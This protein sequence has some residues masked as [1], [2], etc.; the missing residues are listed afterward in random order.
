MGPFNGLV[1]TS[2]LAF[3][4]VFWVFL[5]ILRS[6]I[7]FAMVFLPCFSLGA[8]ITLGAGAIE[9]PAAET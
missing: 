1:S 5:A 7:R 4:K 8:E 2:F 6:G 9:G 3:F